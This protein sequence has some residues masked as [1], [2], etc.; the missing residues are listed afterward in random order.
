M[1]RPVCLL[2]GGG[3]RRGGSVNCHLGGV[4]V[5]LVF[6]PLASLPGGE[7]PRPCRR[8]LDLLFRS[9]L[10]SDLRSFFVPHRGNKGG[11]WGIRGGSLGTEGRS[12]P[13]AR[14]QVAWRVS[15]Q[16]P[17]RPFPR[18]AAQRRRARLA[19]VP[20]APLSLSQ[21]RTV[22]SGPGERRPPASRSPVRGHP[23]TGRVPGVG[24]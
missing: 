15:G 12:V 24:G 13:G 14:R 11:K 7:S 5:F 1:L 18:A 2:T 22:T 9:A 21:D 23:R 6:S 16:V 3:H 8:P 19:L 10:G 20:A 17:S 4:Y